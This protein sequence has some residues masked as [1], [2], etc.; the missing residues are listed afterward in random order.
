MVLEKFNTPLV[1]REFDIPSLSEG[2]VLVKILASGVCGSDVHMAKGEDPRTP[3]PIILGHEG[4]GEVVEIAGEKTDLLGK[5]VSKGDMIIWNRGITCG[6]CFWCKVAK[7]PYLCPNRRTYGINLSC[8]NAPHLLGCYSEYVVLLEG[9]DILKLEKNVDPAAMVIA[10]CSGATAMHA[11]DNLTE[12]LI[13]KTVVVQGAGPL[14]V[15]CLVAAK[16]LGA[17]VTI[18]ISG[19]KERL[20][21]AS[22]A[23]ADLVLSRYETNEDERKNKIMEITNRRGA[24]VVIEATGNSEALLEGIKLLRR[25]GSYLVTGVAVPQ[26]EIPLDVYHNLVLK[27]ISLQGIWVSDSRHLVQAV[28]IVEKHPSVFEKLVTHRLELEQANEALKLV[29]DR[30]ALKAV[31]VQR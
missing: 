23:G 9:T 21:I 4:V 14:G 11:L 27:N 1:M 15:F 31:L 5:K 8:K 26:K 29:E 2:E 20:D 10:G 17:S 22:K 12:P 18:L 6:E 30:K 28:K 24:D 13:G 19:S 16:T 3:L 25:G 7:Q